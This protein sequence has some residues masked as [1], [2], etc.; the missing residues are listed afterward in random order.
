M[1][2][3]F[4]KFTM[5]GESRTGRNATRDAR[6]PLYGGYSSGTL[7]RPPFRWEAFCS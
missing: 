6:P 1:L 7:K 5:G 4:D 2:L 3:W